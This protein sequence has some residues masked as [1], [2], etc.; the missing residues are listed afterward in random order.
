M[1]AEAPRFLPHDFDAA[2]IPLAIANARRLRSATVRIAARRLW[3]RLTGRAASAPASWASV[4]PYDEID[5]LLALNDNQLG[6]RGY[7]RSD[8]QAFRD[9]RTVFLPAARS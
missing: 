2:V 7:R 9:G 3:H 1:S 6:A 4:L 8:L 5:R